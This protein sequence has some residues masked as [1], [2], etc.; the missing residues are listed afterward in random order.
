M[1]ETPHHPVMLQEVVAAINPQDN[2]CYVDG[3][4]GAG[5]YT[6]AILEAANCHVHAFDRDP[7]AIAAGQD[8]VETY[9]GRLTLHHACFGEME[10]V[11]KEVGIA[12]V[13]GVVLDI[14]VSSMQIDEAERGFS[15][16]KDGP[17]DM[18]MAQQGESAA[19]FVN[20][21]DEKS[22]TLVL[23]NLGEEKRARRIAQAIVKQREEEPLERTSDLVRV[24]ES[25]LGSADRH[26]L[27]PATRTFQAIRIFV[28]NE[29]GELVRVLASAERMLKPAGRLVVVAFHSLEDRIVKRFLTER[30]QEAAKPSRHLPLAAQ[31]EY[32]PS[33]RS[34][35]RGAVKATEVEVSGN[36]R[37]R[38]AKLRAAERT[39]ASAFV[40]NPETLGLP[41]GVN[42]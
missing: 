8:L 2:C 37:A 4:F 41:R 11:L 6:K 29:L 42:P 7:N 33:F 16:Q 27:H 13:D 14:G 28:N 24:V 5:G 30:S 38:S 21:A 19:D 20:A 23:R 26:K 12:S 25:V 34:L 39:T 32:L 9:A 3:T 35:S 36:P 17:L 10:Q 18:R 31:E 1:L 40:L 15:F 22:L